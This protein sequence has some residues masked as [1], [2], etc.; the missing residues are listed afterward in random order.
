[1]TDDSHFIFWK[2]IDKYGVVDEKKGE[3]IGFSDDAPEEVKKSWEEF[4]KLEEE[5]T[6][7]MQESG[8]WLK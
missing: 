7:K 3:L 1:M 6:R 4:L 5:R 8:E 2:Y